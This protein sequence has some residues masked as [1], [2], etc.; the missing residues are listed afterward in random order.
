MALRHRRVADAARAAGFDVLDLFD[1]FATGTPQ[2][3][4]YR[5]GANDPHLS[6]GGNR[7]FADRLFHA[8]QAGP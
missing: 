3:F 8:L 2:A 6:V 1:D 5:V 7:I 4:R